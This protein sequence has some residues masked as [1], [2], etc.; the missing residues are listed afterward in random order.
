MNKKFALLTQTHFCLRYVHDV[1]DINWCQQTPIFQTHPIHYSNVVQVILKMSSLTSGVY[2]CLSAKFHSM[3]WLSLPR[4]RNEDANPGSSQ[5]SL[6]KNTIN[7]LFLLTWKRPPWTSAKK[8]PDVTALAARLGPPMPLINENIAPE[9]KAATMLQ[10][11]SFYSLR[12]GR[13]W[14]AFV[15][16]KNNESN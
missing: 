11:Q 1:Q 2:F 7:F 6:N 12:H 14:P 15:S 4:E 3:W 5:V 9:P 13:L 8:T 10:N 16:R